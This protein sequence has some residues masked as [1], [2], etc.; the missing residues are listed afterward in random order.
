MPAC[1]SSSSA[2]PAAGFD[3]CRMRD[4]VAAVDDRRLGQLRR[5]ARAAAES[6]RGCAAQ[7]QPDIRYAERRCAHSLRRSCISASDRCDCSTATAAAS[8]NVTS[9]WLIAAPATALPGCRGGAVRGQ[10]SDVGVPQRGKHETDREHRPLGEAP[11]SEDGMDERPADAAIAIGEGVN[12]LE[13]GMHQGGLDQ[14][15]VGGTVEVVHEIGHQLG[16]PIGRRWDERGADWR[17]CGR[18]DP[19]LHRSQAMMARLARQQRIGAVPRRARPTVTQPRPAGSS[20][21]GRWS[22]CSRRAWPAR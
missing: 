16:H 17:P 22:C 12:R 21:P 1:R 9:H 4:S 8:T 19:V 14:W 10:P 20:P 18:S 3:T 2:A 7:T 6:T 13:L 11:P 15:S 5:A